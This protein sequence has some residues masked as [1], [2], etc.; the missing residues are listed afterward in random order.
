MNNYLPTAE[1]LTKR[2]FNHIEE[3]EDDGNITNWFLRWQRINLTVDAPSAHHEVS[4]LEENFNPGWEDISFYPEIEKGDHG[5]TEEELR[6]KLYSHSGRGKTLR[7]SWKIRGYCDPSSEF[8]ITS[9]D[10]K[11]GSSVKHRSF[12]IDLWIKNPSE[13][14]G[15]NED[16][17]GM[18]SVCEMSSAISMVFDVSENYVR[19]TADKLDHC[20]NAR[21]EIAA[22][23]LVW[24]PSYLLSAGLSGVSD[25]FYLFDNTHAACALDRMTIDFSK[26][27]TPDLLP[28]PG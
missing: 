8:T 16:G 17:L 26:Q 20:S 3:R 28:D 11:T 9:I 24:R 27:K 12:P 2:G 15:S 5:Y 22:R 19:S 23:L 25:E 6:K 4:F 14:L 1:R 13:A 18:V 21:I 7:Q 10:T